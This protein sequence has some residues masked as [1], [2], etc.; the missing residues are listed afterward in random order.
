MDILISQYL[1][2]YEVEN[3][4]RLYER[5]LTNWEQFIDT[6]LV[7]ATPDHV[8]D[9]YSHVKTLPGIKPRKSG[10]TKWAARTIRITLEILGGFYGYLYRRGLIKYNPVLMAS[11]R[12][13]HPTR[14]E[15]RPTEA[16]DFDRVMEFCNAPSRFKKPGIR[17]RAI[18][19]C[20]F[21]GALR[22]SEVINLTM[23][24]VRLWP[25]KTDKPIYY[26]RLVSTKSGGTQEQALP[27]WAAE[28]LTRVV[29][30][31]KAE[32]AGP[33]SPLFVHYQADG[34]P[35]ETKLNT[36]TFRK[37]FSDWRE[38]VGIGEE[39]TPHSARATAIT[40]LLSNGIPIREVQLFARHSSVTTTEH[41]DK[42][43]HSVENS[44]ASKVVY[45]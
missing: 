42:R 17:D 40:L 23:D 4:I 36:R 13:P 22:R 3:T 28:R 2:R 41:Y 6:G 35:S 31:R 16:L 44:V 9:Y 7:E 29:E 38:H 20:L 18:L 32:N 8:I 30:Q 37:I 19:A 27:D 39:I 24:D 43:H 34:K 21:G 25:T 26:L 11:L 5:V 45:H 14:N 10:T 1:A 15:K 12:L 33:T